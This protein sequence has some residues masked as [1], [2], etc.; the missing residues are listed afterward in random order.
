MTAFLVCYFVTIILDI[1][2]LRKE[3]KTLINWR[4]YSV[5]DPEFDPLNI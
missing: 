4:F 3:L 5:T 2:N 1:L